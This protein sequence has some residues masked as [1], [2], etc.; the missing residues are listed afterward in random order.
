M[1][2]DI[3]SMLKTA[4]RDMVLDNLIDQGIS[5]QRFSDKEASVLYDEI[6]D[7][8]AELDKLAEAEN[9]EV[10]VEEDPRDVVLAKAAEATM[11]GKLTAQ[12]YAASYLA[13]V[14]K[15]ALNLDSIG[16]R[17][18]GLTPEQRLARQRAQRTQEIE[19]GPQETEALEKHDVQGTTQQARQLQLKEMGERQEMAGELRRLQL[20]DQYAR[21]QREEQLYGQLHGPTSALGAAAG[22]G[23][24]GATLGRVISRAGSAGI[25]G[26]G[27][28]KFKG[29]GPLGASLGLAAHFLGANQPSRPLI[30]MERERYTPSSMV[31]DVR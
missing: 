12:A 11:L 24:A 16:T 6:M 13:G 26:P 23:L 21:R 14:E 25:L 18:T 30:R 29:L 9:P 8:P 7:A 3:R 22:G 28:A 10:P 31:Q 20:A 4:A 1:D 15:I 17:I 27:A 19:L 2:A 5:V